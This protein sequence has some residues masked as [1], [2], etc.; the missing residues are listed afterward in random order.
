VIT[1]RNDGL[2]FVAQMIDRFL[3]LQ[4][5]IRVARTGSFSVAGRDV[6]LSQPSASRIVAALEK[7]VGVALFTRTTRGVTLTEAGSD[8]LIR[9]EAILA[10]LEEANHAARGTGELRGLLRVAVSTSFA[11]R[12]VLP[13]LSPFAKRHPKLR[14]EFT[15]DDAKQD[16]VGDSV[17][18]ALRIGAL[19]DTSAVARKI[20]VNPRVLAAAPAYLAEAGTPK[21]PSDLP[22]HSIIVAPAGRGTEGWVFRKDGKSTSV[23][24]E[25]R[26]VL[27]G[28]EGATAAAVAGLGIISSGALSMLR[29]LE[30]GQLVRVL[31]DWEMG[32]ADIH[33]V[34]P[35]GRAA[36]PSARVFADFVSSELREQELV[37]DR[38]CPGCLAS[39]ARSAA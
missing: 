10:A 34:L 31:P 18:V 9:A 20:G 19:A 13:R 29:E 37:W 4:L 25:G 21:R 30:S 2:S 22:Q 16:L 17:D 38:I 8:Y 32:M 36:K 14:I 24:V 11:V 15:L 39:G 1:T 23:R 35:T 6:G 28:A 27:N 3:A 12:T 26:I 7:D 5:F 33:V